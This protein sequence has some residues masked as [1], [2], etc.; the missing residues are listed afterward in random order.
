MNILKDIKDKDAAE[1]YFDSL[2]VRLYPVSYTKIIAWYKGKRYVL[3]S[4][5]PNITFFDFRLLIDEEITTANGGLIRLFKDLELDMPFEFLDKLGT[6]Q[7]FN[8]KM[9]KSE[10][11]KSTKIEICRDISE[12]LRSSY[13]DATIEPTESSNSLYLPVSE[14]YITDGFTWK[15]KMEAKYPWLI[16]LKDIHWAAFE[17]YSCLRLGSTS[18]LTYKYFDYKSSRT[19]SIKKD[20]HESYT[21]IILPKPLERCKIQDIQEL[22]TDISILV[23]FQKVAE[24]INIVKY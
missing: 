23:W 8:C 14:E 18:E 11:A 6:Y 17:L 12:Y 7:M 16:E 4:I 1:E 13:L 19:L 24:S 2:G 21:E 10:K 9:N 22:I 20:S 15:L 3:K 5:S